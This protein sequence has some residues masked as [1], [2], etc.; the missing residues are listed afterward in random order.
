[1]NLNL[2]LNEVYDP[3]S[4]VFFYYG[5]L[6]IGA[7]H[8]VIF[9]SVVFII[10]KKSD[11]MGI[12]KYWILLTIFSNLINTT[13]GAICSFKTLSSLPIVVV[14]G[15]ITKL[16]SPEI[17][18]KFKHF[19][20]VGYI[21]STYMLT[22]SLLYRIAVL[23]QRMG[24]EKLFS[25]KKALFISILLNCLI[26]MLVWFF[27]DSVKIF[28]ENRARKY[29]DSYPFLNELYDRGFFLL[30]KFLNGLDLYKVEKFNVDMFNVSRKYGLYVPIMVWVSVEPYVNSC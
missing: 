24:L 23:L 7:T 14:D 9:P 19:P 12:Y 11:K 25:T 27:V 13:I 18:Y 20:F 3:I 17:A 22:S 30:G 16:L 15:V 6:M 21:M 10:L 5:S 1:M 8:F 26:T 2:T 29:L 28:D 4:S